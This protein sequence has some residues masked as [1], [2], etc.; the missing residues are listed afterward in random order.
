MK[1]IRYIN[2]IGRV[3][4][5]ELKSIFRDGGAILLFVIANFIYPVVYSV[6]YGNENIFDLPVCVVDFDNTS[7]SRKLI[8]MVDV[9]SEVSIEKSAA[10]L[11]EAKQMFNNGE[12]NA[13]VRIPKDFEKKILKSEP[14]PVSL[15]CDGAYF[16]YYKSAQKAILS[17]SATLAGG[18]EVKKLLAKG[19]NLVQASTSMS[20]MDVDIFE[21]YNPGGGYGSFVMP[22]L[23]FLTL[24]QTL[25]LGIGL[26]GGTKR[27]K[28]TFR[29]YSVFRDN[30]G[31]I[32]SLILGKSLAYVILY[33]FNFLLSLVVI[34]HTF[35]FP[36]RGEFLYEMMLYIP[37]IFAIS[38][39][40][41]ALSTLFRSRAH[42]LMFLIFMSPILLFL[43]GLSWPKE[44]IPEV[45][46]LFSSLFPSEYGIPAFLRLRIMG[47]DFSSISFEFIAILVQMTIYFI[48]ACWAY[49]RVIVN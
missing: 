46:S 31:G 26:L 9:T 25:L 24:Q 48:L 42:S 36:F 30:R 43:S 37:Y 45:L 49:R 16:M 33:L 6:A 28:N 23:I 29:F 40:G 39:M 14:S 44:S 32:S 19:E 18:I 41:L 2:T 3:F 11:Y 21:E 1:F 5:S 7:T 13:I 47:V 22:G 17:S 10:S 12:V 4:F 15:Y 8:K 27:E 38:F 34:N 35:A 20:P